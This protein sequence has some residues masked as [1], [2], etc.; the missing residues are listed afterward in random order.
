MIKEI[1]LIDIGTSFFVTAVQIAD[2]APAAARRYT[3]HREVDLTAY[4]S[5]EIYHLNV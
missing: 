2:K 5:S 3:R 4:C 1:Q